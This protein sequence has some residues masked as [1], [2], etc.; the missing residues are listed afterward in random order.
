MMVLVTT[1]TNMT[2]FNHNQ[3]SEKPQKRTA[4]R[5]A[6][7]SVSQLFVSREREMAEAN[8]AYKQ[9]GIARLESVRAT[10]RGLNEQTLDLF[11]A[12]SDIPHGPSSDAKQGVARISGGEQYRTW[13]AQMTFGTPESRLKYRD[14]ESFIAIETN[15]PPNIMIGEVP[16]PVSSLTMKIDAPYDATNDTYGSPQTEIYINLL[17]HDN[18][19]PHAHI[20]QNGLMNGQVRIDIDEKGEVKALS[21]G[22]NDST[23]ML[24]FAAT[25]VTGL[26]EALV[27]AK[28]QAE[29]TAK[30]YDAKS[31]DAEIND[32]LGPS[33]R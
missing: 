17:A 12:Y 27:S 26:R 33:D 10:T 31:M 9:E 16:I 8:E 7:G 1:N 6:L 24:E 18:D 23:G 20:E 19:D 11:S 15:T 13:G 25:D 29:R 21:V 3:E 22:K 2:E 30:L 32:I 28:E 14:G 4:L 5:R